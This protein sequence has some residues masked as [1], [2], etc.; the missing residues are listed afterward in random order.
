MM[1]VSQGSGIRRIQHG[2]LPL[3]AHNFNRMIFS[4][5]SLCSVGNASSAARLSGGALCLGRSRRRPLWGRDQPS[6]Q[7]SARCRI[8]PG[9]G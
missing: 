9:H 2:G 4:M 6:G 5:L 3:C 8:L 7:T 1:A